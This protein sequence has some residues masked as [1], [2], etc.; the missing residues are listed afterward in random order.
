MELTKSFILDICANYHVSVVKIIQNDKDDDGYME[1][2]IPIKEA[3]AQALKIAYNNCS[4]LPLSMDII[5]NY[6]FL[7]ACG[8][9][10]NELP[11]DVLKELRSAF[12]QLSKE[13]IDNFYKN[14]Q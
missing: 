11:A 12:R 6:D 9:L 13:R 4:D 14:N 8:F 5:C 1:L 10:P 3:K 7:N 2:I